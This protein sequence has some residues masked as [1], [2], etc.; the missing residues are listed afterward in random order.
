[1]EIKQQ[2]ATPNRPEGDRVLDAPYVFADLP[3]FTEQVKDEKAWQKSDRNAITVFKTEGMTIV[4][5]AMKEGAV[6]KD[7]TVNGFFTVQVL[8]GAIRMETLE[9]DT[10]MT[11]H[12]LISFHP[13]V[14]HSIEASSDCVLLL[15]TYDLSTAYTPL[16]TNKS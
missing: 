13:K 10:N 4:L 2:D 3:T 7:N 15:L 9:G 8:E 6:I 5:S 1:M 11:Q 16:P 14:P 12:Q